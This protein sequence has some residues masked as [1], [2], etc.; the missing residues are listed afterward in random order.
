MNQVSSHSLTVGCTHSLSLNGR[1]K[2]L[3][4]AAVIT[5]SLGLLTGY[6]YWPHSPVDLAQGTNM[7]QS[8]LSA[9]W[10]KGDVVV[11]V[12][13]GERCDRSSNS[14][15]GPKDGITRV[16]S[17]VSTEVGTSFKALGLAQTDVFSSP[18]TRTMQTATSM[19]GHSVPVQDWLRDCGDI[20]LD[21]VSAHK[22][23]NRNLILVTHSECISQLEAQQGYSSAR[24]SEYSSALFVSLDARGKPVIRGVM[25]PEGW[26]HL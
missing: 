2:R 21:K 25:N 22:T 14:C 5:L 3:S 19:F 4:I 17:D 26:I 20:T 1:A 8:G 11:L 10:S 16:G 12:R 23:G 9:S 18:A 13:H 15:L 6:A 24:V 7:S